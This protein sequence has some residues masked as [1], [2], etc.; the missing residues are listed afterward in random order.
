MASF[1]GK[2]SWPIMMSPGDIVAGNKGIYEM[3]SK[4]QSPCNNCMHQP[5]MSWGNVYNT[6]MHQ[7]V[8]SQADACTYC[9]GSNVS[10]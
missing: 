1:R 3:K 9:M 7:S 6:C 2:V 5:V 8:T 10:S 4:Q